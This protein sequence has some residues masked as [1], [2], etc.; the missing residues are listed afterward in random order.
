MPKRIII[1]AKDIANIEGCSERKGR[2]VI[3]DIRLYF[4]KEKHHRI[5][6]SDYAKFANISK[7]ELEDF[8]T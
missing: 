8:R 4:K 2:D 3:E 5:T 6:F 1:T 7:E